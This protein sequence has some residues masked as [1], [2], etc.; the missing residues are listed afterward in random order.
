MLKAL[1]KFMSCQFTIKL[2]RSEIVIK[3]TILSLSISSIFVFWMQVDWDWDHMI[4]RFQKFAFSVNSTRPHEAD[5]VV[6]SN[7]STLESVFKSLRFHRKRYIV[8][9]VFVWTGHKN[10]TKCLRFQMKT[11][12][13]GRDLKLFCKCTNKL[14]SIY[15]GYLRISHSSFSCLFCF[16]LFCFV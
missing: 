4:N 3:T 5:T 16:V 6:F 9:I 2:N 11:H 8:F 10:A 15:E 14:E 1:F 13:C 12:S 7:L